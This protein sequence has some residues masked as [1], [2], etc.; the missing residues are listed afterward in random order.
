MGY[1]RTHTRIVEICIAKTMHADNL[2]ICFAENCNRQR[3]DEQ[4]KRRTSNIRLAIGRT[5]K[6][7]KAGP[8]NVEMERFDILVLEFGRVASFATEASIAQDASTSG[9][10]RWQGDHDIYRSSRFVRVRQVSRERLSAQAWWAAD[11][12]LGMV[13]RAVEGWDG[14]KWYAMKKKKIKYTCKRL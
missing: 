7:Y 1:P 12:C 2:C 8:M 4:K 9:S 11:R 10:E 5:K 6:R 14:N 13:M 3:R